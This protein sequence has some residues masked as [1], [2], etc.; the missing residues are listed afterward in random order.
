M[1]NRESFDTTRYGELFQVCSLRFTIH[2]LRL[3]LYQFHMP[4]SILRS[5]SPRSASSLKLA[6]PD[7]YTLAIVFNS[8]ESAP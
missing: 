6:T 7:Y 4:R 1:V 5:Q 3:L 2:D 8:R